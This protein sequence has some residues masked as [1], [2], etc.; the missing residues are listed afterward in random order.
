[1]RE[2][3]DAVRRLPAGPTRREALQRVI[4]WRYE[5]QIFARNG[6][7]ARLEWLSKRI[8]STG[9]YKLTQINNEQG[10]QSTVDID[11]AVPTANNINAVKDWSDPTADIIGDIKA[12]KKRA[13]DA[14]LPIP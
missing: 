9:K 3:E 4:D 8:A 7:E 10:I 1:L 11:F 12:V 5:D 13:K 14:N 2:L 6:V